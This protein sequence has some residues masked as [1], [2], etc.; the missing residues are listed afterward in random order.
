M[1]NSYWIAAIIGGGMGISFGMGFAV[2]RCTALNWASKKLNRMSGQAKRLDAA[3]NR[4]T[5]KLEQVI[6]G[7]TT[8]LGKTRSASNGTG[9]HS[10][11]YPSHR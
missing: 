10:V 1:A 4:A 7:H 5:E 6:N 9:S 8:G 11:A 2:G 3:T